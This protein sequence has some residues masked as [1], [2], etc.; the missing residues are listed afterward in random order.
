VG[1]VV[2]GSSDT[3]RIGAPKEWPRCRRRSSVEEA[4]RIEDGGPHV[5]V[6]P[7]AEVHDAGSSL[8]CGRHVIGDHEL[9]KVPAG[10]ATART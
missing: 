3:V 2:Q 9:G 1:G 7:M 6:E 8:S 5:E 4:A 10:S